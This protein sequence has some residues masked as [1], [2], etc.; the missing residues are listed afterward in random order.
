MKPFENYFHDVP[1]RCRRRIKPRRPDLRNHCKLI[2]S[3]DTAHYYKYCIGGKTGIYGRSPA[4]ARRSGEKDGVTLVAVTMH[5]ATNQDFIDMAD[6]FGTADNFNSG[7][8]VIDKTDDGGTAE[9]SVTLPSGIAPRP[10]KRQRHKMSAGQ[11]VI[12]YSL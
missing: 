11:T 4:D 7:K 2:I 1:A 3:S 5:G 9:G 12:S 8:Q 6:L 10:L